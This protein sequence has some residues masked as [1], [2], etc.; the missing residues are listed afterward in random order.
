MPNDILSIENAIIMS[1]YNR[2]PLIIDPSEK[3]LSFLMNFYKEEKI[4]KSSFADEGFLKSLENALR[5]GLPMIIT[6]VEKINPI[7]NSVLN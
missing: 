5:F 7:L 6:N 4:L 1:N 2:F 3:A